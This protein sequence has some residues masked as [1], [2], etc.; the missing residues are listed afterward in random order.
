MSQSRG[1]L[2]RARQ[3]RCTCECLCVCDVHYSFAKCLALL[4][5]FLAR[6]FAAIV[7][8]TYLIST[9]ETTASSAHAI[10]RNVR[11][12]EAI[13]SLSDVQGKCS[14]VGSHFSSMKQPVKQSCSGM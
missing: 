14:P 8:I 2:L 5:S 4:A 9:Y 7:G 13:S 11:R 12:W 6:S 3:C 1:P 10:E